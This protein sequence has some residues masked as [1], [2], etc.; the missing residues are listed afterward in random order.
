MQGV[1][2]DTPAG[3]A[4]IEAGDTITAVDGTATT[5]AAQLRALIAAHDPGDEVSI[6]W[7]DSSGSSHTATVEL[8]QGPVA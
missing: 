7:T 8:G 3:D 5:T 4:G 1:Y 6:T 2:D